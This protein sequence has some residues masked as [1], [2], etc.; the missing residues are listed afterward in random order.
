M[1]VI[2]AAER[3][4]IVFSRGEQ[5][6]LM[7]AAWRGALRRS[8]N[9]ETRAPFSE[10][11]I[12]AAT[13]EPGRW[14][15]EADAV[16]LVLQ[17][18]Q[19]RALFLASQVMPS[20]AGTGALE[21]YHGPAWGEPRLEATGGSGAATAMAAPGTTFLGSTII[22]DQLAA[23]AFDPGGQRFQVLYT[24]TTPAN[25]IAGSDPNHPL[26]FVGRDVG[27]STNIAN[28]TRLRWANLPVGA[29][30]EAVTSEQY[31]G[32]TNRELDQEWGRRVEARIRHKPA[33]G[34]SSH[35]RGWAREASNAVADA[36]I[37]CCAYHAGSVHVAVIQ[38]RANVQGPGGRIASFGTLQAVTA[39]LVPPGSSVFPTPPFLVV[40]SCVP[41]PSHL[42]IGL[43]LP[44]GR[45]AG[46]ADLSPWPTSTGGTPAAITV[47]SNQT[48]F[49]MNS[50]SGL[51]IGVTPAMMIWNDV[52]SRFE[53]LIVASVASAGGGLYDVVLSTAPAKTLA[54][55]DRISPYTD[56]Q[57]I[58]AE[59]IE[60][61]FD[62]LGPGELIDLAT[63]PRAHR[64]F[65]FPEPSEELPQRAGAG[66]LSWLQDALGGALAD[67][68]LDAISSTTPTVPVSPY[69]G[70]SL[71][72]AGRVGV[73]P[74]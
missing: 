40:S 21:T 45:N 31:T 16:D 22:P 42:V 68:T 62:S 50:P 15:A 5:R 63:D 41:Q 61:Y 29:A 64:A 39:Y 28:G 19:Q 37:Y 69:D 35:V 27:I 1:G 71:L 73:Y 12:A 54:V 34:N 23:Y 6:D 17:P 59:T 10:E 55:A 32:G 14:W 65:R 56:R 13:A 57:Q 70:P 9:P 4:F 46:W 24:V 60:G 25:G 51:P 26:I 38:K 33:A 43:S 66:I 74:I 2:V 7:L 36:A 53:R 20:R 52:T 72:V 8:I 48:H 67:S 30:P 3:R 58:A 11:E 18:G 44:R 47:V 49:R